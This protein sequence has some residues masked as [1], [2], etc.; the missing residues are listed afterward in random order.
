MWFFKKKKVPETKLT[1]S[2]DISVERIKGRI[3][4]I[5]SNL[6]RRKSDDPDIGPLK[7]ALKKYKALL[8]AKEG[9]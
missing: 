6:K 4:N 3:A 8:V 1:I 9:E 7:I 5:E 2:T